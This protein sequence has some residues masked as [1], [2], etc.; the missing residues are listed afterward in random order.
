[1]ADQLLDASI[2]SV[3]QDLGSTLEDCVR[4]LAGQLA[5]AGRISDVDTFVADVLAR[6]AQGSTALPGGVAL[7]HAR[8]AA[9]T[10]TSVAIASLPAPISEG[11]QQIDLVFLLAVPGDQSDRYLA[12]LRQVTNAVVKPGFR[13]DCRD[14]GSPAALAKLAS[15]AFGVR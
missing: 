1:M 3:K 8:S 7:P 14:A 11:G 15:D 5:E 2:V 13:A 4:A 10:T 12:L 6:E 9:A